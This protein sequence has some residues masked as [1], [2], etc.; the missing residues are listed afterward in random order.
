MDS[1]DIGDAVHKPVTFQ[2][3]SD[4]MQFNTVTG[5][6]VEYC[7]L[8]ANDNGSSAD[9]LQ[10]NH[11]TSAI[12]RYNHFHD[13]ANSNI[14]F[15]GTNSYGDVY[16][17]LIEDGQNGINVHG[18]TQV[19]PINI[20]N[21]TLYGVSQRPLRVFATGASTITMKNNIVWGTTYDVVVES[22]VDTSKISLD[23]NIYKNT[24]GNPFTWNGTEYATLSLYQAASGQDSSSLS[25]DPLFTTAGS[26]FSLLS[27]SPAIDAG[28]EL[29]STYSNG[30]SSDASWP[31]SVATLDQGLHGS[32]WEIGAYVY[33]NLRVSS[34]PANRSGS[35]HR[36]INSTLMAT[37]TPTTTPSALNASS[38]PYYLLF[39]TTLKP[40]SKGIWVAILQLH[41][42]ELGYFHYPTITGYYGTVT[43]QAIRD[44]QKAQGIK[45][46]NGLFG[47]LTKGAM[48]ALIERGK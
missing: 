25:S 33:P 3:N 34:T 2:T 4:G 5:L 43:I 40:Y 22:G 15:S 12:V 48:N 20:Y 37:T 26:N 29:A 39:P 17:N 44:F 30:L 11:T 42:R 41:L 32:G 46:T 6:L 45:P 21:N 35:R 14:I 10:I 7:D 47:P 31:A 36:Q 28:V 13:G 9:N 18:T 38:T 8:Y 23:N 27:T 24:S 1:G 16:G 19:S